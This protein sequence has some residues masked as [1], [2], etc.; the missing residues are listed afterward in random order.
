MADNSQLREAMEEYSKRLHELMVNASR[1][2][3]FGEAK[4]KE[5]ALIKFLSENFDCRLQDI[6]LAIM[7]DG[8]WEWRRTDRQ[9]GDTI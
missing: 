6:F 5:I 3:A 1:D 4:R 9:Y 2:Y 7:P 8:Q